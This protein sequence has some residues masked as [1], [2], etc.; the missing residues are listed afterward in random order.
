M[1]KQA[2]IILL[3]SGSS[4]NAFTPGSAA[5]SNFVINIAYDS[6]SNTA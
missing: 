1:I 5:T 4:A 6:A 2:T 3:L